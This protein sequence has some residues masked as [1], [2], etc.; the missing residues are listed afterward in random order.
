MTNKKY[1]RKVRY[2]DNWLF[3]QFVLKDTVHFPDIDVFYVYALSRKLQCILSMSP[4]LSIPHKGQGYMLVLV[5]NF[6]YIQ[7]HYSLGCTFLIVVG[8]LFHRHLDSHP[9]WTIANNIDN[10][11]IHNSVNVQ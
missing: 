2:L 10:V 3:G 5:L 4:N 1:Y 11:E 6:Q 8:F 9:I 7:A